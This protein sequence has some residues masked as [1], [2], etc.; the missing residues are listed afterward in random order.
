MK[1][2]SP[3]FL[4]QLRWLWPLLL[5]WLAACAQSA[6]VAPATPGASLP[7][8]TS[9][10][11]SKPTLATPSREPGCTVV[12]RK[13]TPNP[14]VESLLPPPGEKDWVRGPKDARVTIIDYSDFQ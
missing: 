4:R 12:S 10:L 6:G 2:A 9:D 11:T 3:H 14:T 5:V 1:P 13:P 7:K 8:P